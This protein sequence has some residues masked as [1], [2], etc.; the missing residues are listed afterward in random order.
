[1]FHWGNKNLSQHR[2]TKMVC[3]YF[4]LALGRTRKTKTICLIHKLSTIFSAVVHM[5]NGYFIF[6]FT[7]TKTTHFYRIQLKFK[8]QN[9]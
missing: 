6:V 1:M 8:Q 5:V 7:Q 3:M 4:W 2:D 9:E